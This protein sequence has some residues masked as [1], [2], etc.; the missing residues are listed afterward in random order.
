M[1]K[2]THAGG[3]VIKPTS[4]APLYLLVRANAVDEEWVL[5][6]GHIN[7]DAVPPESPEEAARREVEEE[8][9][10]LADVVSSIGRISYNKG[11]E[12]VRAEMFLMRF[13]A[14]GRARESRAHRWLPFERAHEALAHDDARGLLKRARSMA[15]TNNDS[16]TE[17]S[18]EV[19]L[20]QLDLL[21]DRMKETSET[22]NA[23]LAKFLFGGLIAVIALLN[24]DLVLLKQETFSSCTTSLWWTLLILMALS[25]AYFGVVT[26]HYGGFRASHRKLKYKFELTLHSLLLSPD[27]DVADYSRRLELSVSGKPD[28]EKPRFPESG[29]LND[30]L[31]YLLD[32]HRVRLRD[33]KSWYATAYFWLAMVL[34]LLTMA[35]RV[36]PIIDSSCFPW[37]VSG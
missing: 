19:L 2:P 15:E 18:A 36:L 32:H 37:L 6:K 14:D 17:R 11:D 20:K 7:S 3:V 26:H 9:G 24:A 22:A 10:V 8:T 29:R 27:P 5:P 33:L 31:D 34:V 12:P 28:S 30:V 23:F 1:I 25:A 4:T 21:N 13:V 16:V 35:V